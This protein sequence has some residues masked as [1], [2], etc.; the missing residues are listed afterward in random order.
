[1]DW[2]IIYN[3]IN[4]V[5]EAEEKQSDGFSPNREK[6]CGC[7]LFQFTYKTNNIN[8]CINIV[9]YTYKYIYYMK[10]VQFVPRV[11]LFL[12]T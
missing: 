1:M 5:N 9:L 4:G 8:V 2:D 10:I 11:V 12:T 6:L 3:I 7:V